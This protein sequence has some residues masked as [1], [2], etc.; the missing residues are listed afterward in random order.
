MAAKKKIVKK[1]T[2]KV[3]KPKRKP[4]QATKKTSISKKKTN[5]QFYL[6]DG[7]ALNSLLDLADAFDEMS[8]DVFAHH[9][10]SER[11]DFSA[12][13]KDVFNEIELAETLMDSVDKDDHH[14]KVLK[15][16][17]KDLR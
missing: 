6:I 11:N 12:W 16:I 2:L 15:F 4:K 5:N 7:R 13:I 8:N 14:V 1:S 3:P 10:N 9:V 17:V